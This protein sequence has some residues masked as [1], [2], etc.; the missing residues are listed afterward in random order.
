MYRRYVV[1]SIALCYTIVAT[2]AQPSIS[3]TI[4]FVYPVRQGDAE[5]DRL[6]SAD[7]QYAACDIPVAIAKAMTTAALAESVLDYPLLGNINFSNTSIESGLTNLAT[8][9]TGASRVA[10]A[11]RLWDHALKTLRA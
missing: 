6:S 1:F 5:W 7:E 2:F 3:I 4:P 10:C 11:P 8:V 9:F